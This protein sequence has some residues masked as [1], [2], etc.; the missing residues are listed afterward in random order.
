MSLNH[1]DICLNV[2]NI[3]LSQLDICLNRD[4]L[5][6]LKDIFTLLSICH[7]NLAKQCPY[8]TSYGPD[9]RVILSNV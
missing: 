5:K 4:M 8:M 2:L 7:V 3:S 1:L 9:V 6:C